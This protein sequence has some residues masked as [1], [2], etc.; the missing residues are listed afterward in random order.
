MKAQRHPADG[1]GKQKC[2]QPGCGRWS[3]QGLRRGQGLCPFHWCE[4][5][6]GHAYAKHCHPN[7]TPAEIKG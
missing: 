6:Y 1:R 2:C 7:Y 3:I 4:R 5:L